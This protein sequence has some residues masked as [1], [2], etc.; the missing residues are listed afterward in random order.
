MKQTTITLKV[1]KG[2]EM[3]T[4]PDLSGKTEEEAKTLAK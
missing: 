2:I 4:V 3:T 1:S